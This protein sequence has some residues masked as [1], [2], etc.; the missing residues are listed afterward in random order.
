MPLRVENHNPRV[1]KQLDYTQTDLSISPVKTF[2]GPLDIYVK[3]LNNCFL[4]SK[5]RTI[6][7]SLL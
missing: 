6:H 5:R 7:L 1:S 2:K 4:I 3:F